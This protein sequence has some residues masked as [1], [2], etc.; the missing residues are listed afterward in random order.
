MGGTEDT[1]LVTVDNL[2]ENPARYIHTYIYLAGIS[3]RLSTVIS[4]ASRVPPLPN[5]PAS[6][7]YKNGNCLNIRTSRFGHLSICYLLK[8]SASI[9][10][11]TS[12]SYGG[13]KLGLFVTK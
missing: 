10:K 8:K 5:F 9:L 4:P 11:Q 12:R 3:K 2:L 7:S 1:G 6:S 13:L